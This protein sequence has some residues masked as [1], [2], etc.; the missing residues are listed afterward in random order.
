MFSAITS[1]GFQQEHPDV[2]FCNMEMF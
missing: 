1:G 2:L